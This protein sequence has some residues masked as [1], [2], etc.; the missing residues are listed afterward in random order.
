ME[1]FVARHGEA[2]FDAKSDRLRPLTDRGISETESCLTMVQGGLDA[3]QQIWVS[4]LVRAQQTALLINKELEV[5]LVTK[6]FLRPESDPQVVLR[7][8][9]LNETGSVFIV[10]HQ[11]LLG[12]LVSLLVE[13]HTYSPHP[14]CTSEILQLQSDSCGA[15]LFSISHQ[16]LPA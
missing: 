9:E 15:G 3:V 7:N 6:T 4:D 8:L 10:A 13:G 1:L 12:C 5:E 2:S 14:F 16:Y 11:P